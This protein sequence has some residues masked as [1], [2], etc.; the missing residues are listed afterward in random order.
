MIW[1]AH[2]GKPHKMDIL[3]FSKFFKNISGAS[4]TNFKKDMALATV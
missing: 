4:F 2:A 3:Y 1:L